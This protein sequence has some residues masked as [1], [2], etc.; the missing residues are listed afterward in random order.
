M[1]ILIMFWDFSMGDIFLT[2]QRN[3]NFFIA[4]YNRLNEDRNFY[5]YILFAYCMKYTSTFP[6]TI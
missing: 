5:F 2:V 1:Y 3:T 6:E 4:F